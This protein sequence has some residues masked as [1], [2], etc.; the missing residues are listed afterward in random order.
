MHFA[1]ELDFRGN[2]EGE[3]LPNGALGFVFSIFPLDFPKH[4]KL[5]R[6]TRAFESLSLSGNL[7]LPGLGLARPIA[8]VPGFLQPPWSVMSAHAAYHTFA[9]SG[10]TSLRESAFCTPARHSCGMVPGL[11]TYWGQ[12]ARPRPRWEWLLRCQSSC[13]EAGLGDEMRAGQGVGVPRRSL[14]SGLPRL[15]RAAAQGMLP[16]CGLSALGGKGA[17]LKGLWSPRTPVSRSR[18]PVLCSPPGFLMP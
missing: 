12:R 9:T 10:R 6:W 11:L 2:E 15:G 3:Q 14:D 13:R 8:R 4:L 18:C 16:W 7:T 1:S 17:V 5:I